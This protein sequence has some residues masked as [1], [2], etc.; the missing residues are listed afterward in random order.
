MVQVRGDGGSPWVGARGDAEKCSE[1]WG[2]VLETEWQ[3]LLQ[4]ST[5]R[6]KEPKTALRVGPARTHR[7][8]P[9]LRHRRL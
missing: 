4:D 7:T 5:R 6:V 1:V 8:R 9:L 2:D 3:D